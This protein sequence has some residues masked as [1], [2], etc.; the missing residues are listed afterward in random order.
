[1]KRIEFGTKSNRFLL[2]RIVHHS[3]KL[4]NCRL[5]HNVSEFINNN[6]KLVLN[7]KVLFSKMQSTNNC[8]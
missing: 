7:S 8:Q 5:C 2:W 1:M 3:Y 6:H 4:T